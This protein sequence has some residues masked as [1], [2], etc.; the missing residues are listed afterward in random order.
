MC[1]VF[2]C[3]LRNLG[4]G[5]A[6]S[7][8]LFLPQAARDA[9][10]ALA[11][12]AGEMLPPG[13]CG[14][15]GSGDGDGE[16]GSEEEAALSGAGSA[17]AAQCRALRASPHSALLLS[18]LPDAPYYDARASY[19][20]VLDDNA[21]AARGAGEGGRRAR[22]GRG[23]RALA[24]ALRPWRRRADGD[25]DADDADAEAAPALRA[26]GGAA[27]RAARRGQ[28]SEEHLRAAQARPTRT[29]TH[30]HPP[31]LAPTERRCFF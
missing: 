4:F 29:C 11:A 18:A 3:V 14:R 12:A 2:V 30:M 22:A 8:S 5:A 20:A 31:S 1:S 23:A 10:C 9:V 27:A 21:A 17:P 7:L 24:R 28:L 26:L 19:V 16:R 15:G 13:A 25:A 6:R